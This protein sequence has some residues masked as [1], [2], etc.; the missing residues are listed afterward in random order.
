MCFAGH[1]MIGNRHGLVVNLEL[2]RASGTRE[3][4]AAKQLLKWPRGWKPR[5]GPTLGAEK[6]YDTQDFL[7]ACEELRVT[8]HVPRR[9]SDWGSAL[10]ALLATT[11]GYQVSHRKRKQGGGDLRLD[12]DGGDKQE[13]ALHRAGAQL[14]VAGNDPIGLQPDPNRQGGGAAA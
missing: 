6:G 13:S 4:D 1:V 11:S 14:P 2:T 10:L 7:Q 5:R 9:E 3:R 8:P 12:Q